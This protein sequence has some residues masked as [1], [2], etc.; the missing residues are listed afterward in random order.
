MLMPLIRLFL[1]VAVLL[2]FC[3]AGHAQSRAISPKP[4]EV[5]K[6]LEVRMTLPTAVGVISDYASVLFSGEKDKLKKLTAKRKSRTSNPVVIFT[7]PLPKGW[8]DKKAASD[9]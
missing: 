6:E 1:V 2:L 3:T 5:Q 7:V 9:N 4:E 8:G